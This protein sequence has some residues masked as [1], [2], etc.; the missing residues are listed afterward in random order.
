[1]SLSW[2]EALTIVIGLAGGYWL[3][4]RVL[5]DDTPLSSQQP[6]AEPPSGAPPLSPAAWWQVLEVQPHASRDDITA[7]YRRKMSEYHPDKV[8]RMGA[9]IRAVA[10]R[11]S[12]EIN[13]AYEEALRRL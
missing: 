1:M 13:A 2:N 3:V 5:E 12:Q 6:Q 9:E 10:E 11:K 4:T 7:A 8:A